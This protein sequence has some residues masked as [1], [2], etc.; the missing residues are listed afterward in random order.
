MLILIL[1]H[2]ARAFKEEEGNG[3]GWVG[4]IMGV[5]GGRIIRLMGSLVGEH[6]CR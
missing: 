6:I 3:G 5:R 4:E 1:W 2:A